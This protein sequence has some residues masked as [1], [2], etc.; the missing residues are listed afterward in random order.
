MDFFD[1]MVY[2][3]FCSKCGVLEYGIRGKK[4]G[5][6]IKRSALLLVVILVGCGVGVLLL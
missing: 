4:D 1:S 2:Q 3:L 5:S 6:N